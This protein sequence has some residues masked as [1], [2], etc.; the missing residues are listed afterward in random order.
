MPGLDQRPHEAEQQRQQQGADVLAVDVGV[1]HQDDLVIAQLVDVEVLADAGAEGGDQRLDLL[2]ARTLSIRAFSTFRILPRIGRI[3]WVRGLR[4]LF[5]EPPAESPSTMKISHSSGSFDWQSRQLAGQ[6]AASEQA[7]AARG[8]AG[9]AGRHARGRR[10]DRLA[11]DVRAPRPGCGRTSPSSCS[12]TTLC[13][14]V[15]ASVLPSLVF[16]WP[17]N[18]GSPSL[19]EMMAVRPSRMSSPV[20]L[21]SFSLRSPSRARTG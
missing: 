19:I 11:D 13:T 7:L 9:L 16:V 20:R 17:S 4:P 21:S 12:R 1:R 6:A 3:A 5:A 14:K 18:C 15:F 2:V 10:L 8:L